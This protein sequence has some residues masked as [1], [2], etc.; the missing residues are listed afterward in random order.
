[1]EQPTRR[2]NCRILI[3]ALK[4]LPQVKHLPIDTAERQNGWYVLAFSVDIENMKCEYQ[5]V[6]R[7]GRGRGRSLLEG[8]LAAI[9]TLSAHFVNNH[10]LGRS[11]FPFTSKEY[12]DPQSVDY[13]KVEVPHACLARSSHIYMLRLSHVLRK[14]TCTRSPMPW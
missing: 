11:G 8:V 3:D 7:R 4:N 12:A 10:G 1:M 14:K 5:T 9:A 6:C 2:R 13:S